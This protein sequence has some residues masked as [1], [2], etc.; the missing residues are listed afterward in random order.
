[1]SHKVMARLKERSAEA[2]KRISEREVLEQELVSNSEELPSLT[3]ELNNKGF[4]SQRI[5]EE[6]SGKLVQQEINGLFDTFPLDQ[7]RKGICPTLLTRTAIFPAMSVQAQK[8]CLDNDNAW[9]FE[10]P[11]GEGKRYGPNLTL[12]D[13]KVLHALYRLR[14]KRL[15][16]QHN[17][18]PIKVS[19][20]FKG[21]G[22]KID[23]DVVICTVT[24]V[25]DELELNHGGKNHKDVMASLQRIAAC[26]IQMSVKKQD[27]YFGEFERGGIFQLI[28]IQWETHKDY[29]VVYVQFSPLVTQWLENS[30]TY[31]DWSVHKKLGRNETALAL[32]EFYSSQFT[33]R[34]NL[35]HNDMLKIANTIGIRATPKV[36]KSKM[37][38]GC[39]KLKEVGWLEGF[40]FEGTGRKSPIVLHAW[41]SL[42][43]D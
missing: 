30:F 28:D 41:R 42:Q 14:E 43:N 32:H 10:S 7:S 35:Y 21:N 29:G 1:M 16:G 27:R 11:F 12:K 6:V 26:R 2:Q 8:K 33:K 36:I 25:L 5:V 31:L 20:I 3:K 24:Q 4:T 40:E 9:V 38:S 22:G 23:V 34:V 15:S 39:E 19:N 17:N 37:T 18:L 13:K